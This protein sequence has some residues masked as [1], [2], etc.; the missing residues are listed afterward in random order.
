ME[1]KEELSKILAEILQL[2][3]Q[4]NKIYDQNN[5]I[6]SEMLDVSAQLDEKINVY[7]KKNMKIQQFS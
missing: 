3:Q 6:N 5:Q 1:Q 4:L 2:K 7:L